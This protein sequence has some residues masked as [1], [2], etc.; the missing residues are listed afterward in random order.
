VFGILAEALGLVMR[1]A[2]FQRAI[3]DGTEPS[4]RD[5][6]AM[7]TDLKDARVRVFFYN[8]QVTDS[9]T[10]HL[11]S[12]AR[13]AGVPVIGI[14]ETKPPDMTYIQWMLGLIAATERAIAGPTP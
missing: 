9:L 2:G 7:E 3:M 13:E 5:I 4:A 1:N 8:S 14:G 12:L 10:E 6:A 11:V